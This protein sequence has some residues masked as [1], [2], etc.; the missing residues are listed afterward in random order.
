MCVCVCTRVRVRARACVCVM[1]GLRSYLSVNDVVLVNLG[2][3]SWAG[4]EPCSHQLLPAPPWP[5]I[6]TLLPRVC[7]F[8]ERPVPSL[9]L[10]VGIWVGA[11]VEV[12]SCLGTWEGLR[13]LHDHSSVASLSSFC[14]NLASVFPPLTQ[15]CSEGLL[16]IGSSRQGAG[17]P[18]CAFRQET[19]LPCL[20]FTWDFYHGAPICLVPSQSR[21]GV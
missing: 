6:P 16:A 7:F 1:T 11:W 15:V 2:L 4:A 10:G 19:S 20:F 12:S 5:P 14:K 13:H 9:D 8:P 3:L 18:R 17:E 21:Q